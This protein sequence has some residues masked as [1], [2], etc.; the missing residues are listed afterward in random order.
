[1]GRP[2]HA[3]ELGDVTAS[4]VARRLG[5]ALADFELLREALEHE[6]KLLSE[7]AV[8]ERWPNLTPRELRSARKANPPRIAFYD[9]PRRQGGPCYTVS[10][11]QEYIDR[12]YLRGA[13][14]RKSE[15]TASKSETTTSINPTPN[16]SESSTP[17]GMTPE[18]A[19]RAAEALA[20]QMKTKPRSGSRRSSPP[21]QK[22]PPRGQ[23]PILVKS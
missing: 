3:R 9:F 14:C 23:H 21:R 7:T 22:P 18:L 1:M 11:V 8:L 2:A 17:A 4:S 6:N 16:I 15:A 19:E 13:S 10:Q 20:R 5:L 12:T